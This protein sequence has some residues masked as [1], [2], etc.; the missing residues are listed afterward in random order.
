MCA[1]SGHVVLASVTT[2]FGPRAEGAPAPTTTAARA[3]LVIVVSP[4]PPVVPPLPK[5]R[6][7]LEAEQPASP[8]KLTPKR[9]QRA[10]MARNAV[11]YLSII[12]QVIAYSCKR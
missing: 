12:Q 10:V 5:R 8:M 2:K 6:E 11:S 7:P 4:P 1:L 9:K 3:P